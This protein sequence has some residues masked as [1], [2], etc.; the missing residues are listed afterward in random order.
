MAAPR[1]GDRGVVGLTGSSVAAAFPHVGSALA[2]G[3][4]GYEAALRIVDAL[5]PVRPV[6]GDAAVAVAEEELVGACAAAEPG[7][8]ARADAD[9]VRVQA[10]TWASFLDQDGAAPPEADVARRSLRL[11]GVHRGLVRVQGLLL[12]EVA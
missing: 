1:A 9:S 5:Q 8:V 4:L 3:R 11:G 2:E 12:P 10:S 6:A 7:G